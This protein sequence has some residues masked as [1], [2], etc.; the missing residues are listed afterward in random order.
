[1]LVAAELIA[2]QAGMGFLIMNA[3]QIGEIG[4][5][6]FGIMLIGAVNLISDWALAGAIRRLLQGWHAA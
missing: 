2:A 6:I 5:V 1:M 4:I 3:R